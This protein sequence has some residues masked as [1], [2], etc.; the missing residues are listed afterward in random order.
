[1]HFLCEH[2]GSAYPAA[3]LAFRCDC[4]GLFRLLD[5]TLL[6]TE[7]S[8]GEVE[9]PVVPRSLSGV[10]MELKLDYMMPSGSFK[11]RGARALIGCL[12]AWGISE[13]V[14]DSSGNAGASIAAYAAA[15][16]IRCRIFV[17]TSTSSGKTKQIQAYGA[18]IQRVPGPRDAAAEAVEQAARTT[19]YASHVY[20]PLFFAGTQT[21]VP[22]IIRQCPKVQYIV[23]PVGNGTL[24]LGLYQGFAAEGWLPKFVAV[25]S[26][27]CAPIYSGFH[28]LPGQ[29]LKPTIA[30]G[31]AVQKPARL[32]SIVDAIRASGGTVLTVDDTAVDNAWRQLGAMGLFVEKT[33]AVAPAGAVEYF[34]Q[35]PPRPG[36]VVVPLTGMG[37]KQC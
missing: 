2:C 29:E 8:L 22:E 10:P 23:T 6:T 16:G 19:Y 25:Q 26:S 27:S 37:L 5:D 35:H 21:I 15:A 20:N 31:I 36:R 7:L 30:E 11:D 4:G 12:Q 3:G 24:L 34:A 17:P 13:I 9:T 32:S 18:E 33:A 14:E 1:M 28:R